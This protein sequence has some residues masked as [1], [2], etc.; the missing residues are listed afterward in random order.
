[1]DQLL[2]GAVIQ[3]ARKPLGLGGPL[4]CFH[5]PAGQWVSAL[6]CYSLPPSIPDKLTR[7]IPEGTPTWKTYKQVFWQPPLSRE[8]SNFW[9]LT[10]LGFRL[11][12][13]TV[14]TTMFLPYTI[15]C[16]LHAAILRRM[17]I[18]W[19]FFSFWSILKIFVFK[20]CLHN[21]GP[22]WMNPTRIVLKGASRPGAPF[23]VHSMLDQIMYRKNPN[24][25][26]VQ[27]H[28]NYA[29]MIWIL[30]YYFCLEFIC[31]GGN[32]NFGVDLGERLR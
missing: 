17:R 25:A 1:M 9:V 19:S 29:F 4:C 5:T 26:R 32:S 20:W 12:M 21:V 22:E 30:I 2:P 23:L 27:I 15:A 3:I 10:I 16:L 8:T 7:Q 28:H 14:V 31:F 13:R 24:K 6:S 11:Y 18:P